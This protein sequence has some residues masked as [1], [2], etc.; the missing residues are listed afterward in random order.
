MSAVD[1]RKAKIQA[2]ASQLKEKHRDKYNMVQYNFGLRTL[3]MRDTR[4]GKVP[5]AKVHKEESGADAK[6]AEICW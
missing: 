3:K 6:Y 4:A 1:E 2:V 5:K